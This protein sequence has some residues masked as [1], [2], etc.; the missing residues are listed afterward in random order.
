MVAKLEL[1][2]MS[3]HVG[4]I[5]NHTASKPPNYKEKIY[6]H[7][8]GVSGL[9]GMFDGA[10]R[11]SSSDLPLTFNCLSKKSWD[12]CLSLLFVKLNI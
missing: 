4:S 9:V 2:P 1:D 12:I 8:K 3:S 10:L 11:D 7:G 5:V 6:L